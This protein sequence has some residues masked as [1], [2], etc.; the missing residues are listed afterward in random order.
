MDSGGSVLFPKNARQRRRRCPYLILFEVREA[1]GRGAFRV[2]VL[3]TA[4]LGG[5][6]RETIKSQGR[7]LF[8]LLLVSAAVRLREASGLF[9]AFLPRSLDAV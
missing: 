2:S 3:L 7:R 6:A 1:D 8:A 5:I 4:R 9:L